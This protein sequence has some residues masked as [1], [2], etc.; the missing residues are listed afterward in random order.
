[1]KIF[2]CQQC[3]QTVLFENTRCEQCSSSLGFLPDQMVISALKS[4]DNTWYAMAD[5]ICAS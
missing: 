1:M 5:K 4:V 3:G 2:S